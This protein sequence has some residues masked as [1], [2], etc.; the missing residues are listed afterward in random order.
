MQ[1]HCSFISETKVQTL[2]RAQLRRHGEQ[3][4]CRFQATACPT[5]QA[6]PSP[7]PD[8]DCRL[9]TYVGT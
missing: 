3:S 4:L 9:H 8:H 1:D 5:Q 6:V 7:Q 2:I